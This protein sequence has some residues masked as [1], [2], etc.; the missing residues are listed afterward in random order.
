DL[1]AHDD[2]QPAGMR[3]LGGG[4]STLGGGD[5]LLVD[6]HDERQR[7]PEGERAGGPPLSPQRLHDRRAGGVPE[8]GHS[9]LLV[10]RVTAPETQRTI[11]TAAA[12]GGRRGRASRRPPAAPRSRPGRCTAWC[13]PRTPPAGR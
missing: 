5:V 1:P 6:D 3:C 9:E 13:W 2:Q 10:A 8:R 11:I 4:G 12:S 7:E